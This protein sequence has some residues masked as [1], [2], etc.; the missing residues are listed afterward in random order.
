MSIVPEIS[1]NNKFILYRIKEIR[2]SVLELGI[3]APPVLPETE[4]LSI[5]KGA[6]GQSMKKFTQFLVL[7]S[8]ME[9]PVWT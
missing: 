9:K 7:P 3:W 5:P 1:H 4:F 2:E 6:Q 8:K